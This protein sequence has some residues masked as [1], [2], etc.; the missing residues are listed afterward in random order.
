[1]AEYE[2]N[3]VQLPAMASP[4]AATITGGYRVTIDNGTLYLTDDAGTTVAVGPVTNGAVLDLEQTFTEPQTIDTAVDENVL[5]V[6]ASANNTV[7]AVH[8]QAAPGSKALH[9][10]ENAPGSGN[11]CNFAAEGGGVLEWGDGTNA[12]DT[13]VQ[14]TATKTLE[15]DDNAG[16]DATLNIVGVLQQNGDAVALLKDLFRQNYVHN[17]SGQIWQRFADPDTA[18]TFADCDYGPDRWKVATS[19]TNVQ[20]R[21]APGDTQP[22]AIRLIQSEATARNL[23]LVQYWENI[24]C[25]GLQN[26]QV[27]LSVR[28]RCSSAVTLHGGILQWGGTADQPSNDP[29]ASWPATWDTNWSLAGSGSVALSANTWADLQVTMTLGTFANCGP[30]FWT[31]S[32]LAQNATLEFE[33]IKVELGSVATPFE[34][35][36]IA[37]ELALCQRYYQVFNPGNAFFVA[38]AWAGLNHIYAQTIP[39]LV[40]MRVAPTAT[41]T[42]PSWSAGYPGIGNNASFYPP[43]SPPY[44]TTVGTFDVVYDTS[45]STLSF[46]YESQPD[47]FAGCVAGDVG[48]ATFGTDYRAY[49]DGEI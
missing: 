40:Q 30:A 15:V 38:Y 7:H 8:I 10:S 31:G 11:P 39:L 22:Y 27:T 25:A 4:S 44:V 47:D 37:A 12:R 18:E 3:S 16:G 41:D 5:I 17:P 34:P 35:R 28:V 2:H 32:T 49:L 43:G 26:Q 24:D 23:G 45:P 1:M 19:G 33:K 42:N 14:R 6:D 48:R 29:W 46:Y 21:R 20:C 36:T 13:R 9:I